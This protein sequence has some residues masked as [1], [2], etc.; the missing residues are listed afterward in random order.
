[1]QIAG[2][3]Q[4]VNEVDTCAATEEIARVLDEEFPQHLIN[5]K[6][7]WRCAYFD[8]CHTPKEAEID[9]ASVPNGFEIR[10]SHH[11]YEREMR[12]KEIEEVSGE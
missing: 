9:F 12:E 10:E 8:Y 11:Q 3:V 2:A 6:T 5:C 7:P 1:M 4:R